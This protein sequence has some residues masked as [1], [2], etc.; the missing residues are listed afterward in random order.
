MHVHR[1]TICANREHAA[2]VNKGLLS[3]CYEQGTEEW[4]LPPKLSNP[5]KILSISQ[6]KR[7]KHIVCSSLPPGAHWVK[8]H[9]ESSR[10]RK[11]PFMDLPDLLQGFVSS[12]LWRTLCGIPSA[13]PVSKQLSNA[14]APGTRQ[15]RPETGGNTD[16][17]Q[18]SSPPLS[19]FKCTF[20]AEG[21][22]WVV[23]P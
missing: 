23:N 22:A 3:A 14:T 6:A 10:E 5:L 15:S 18:S 16:T 8:M 9:L 17:G 21:T 19:K 2:T 4:D 20:K 7:T 13:S 11:P 1:R 12:W